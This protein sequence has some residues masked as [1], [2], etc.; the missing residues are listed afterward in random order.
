MDLWLTLSCARLSE[1]HDDFDVFQNISSLWL[2]DIV[3]WA[4][5]FQKFRTDHTLICAVEAQIELYQDAVTDCVG[6][7]LL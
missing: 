4:A 6:R 1:H 2:I 5:S 7:V 3:L